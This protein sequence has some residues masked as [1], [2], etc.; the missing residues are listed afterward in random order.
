MGDFGSIFKA[1]DVRGTVPDQFDPD[2]AR[3]IGAAFARFVRTDDPDAS[4]VLVARD[5]RP[6][7]VD[8]VAA[9]SEGVRSQGVDLV[10]LGLGSP[11]LLYYA[12]GSLG[13]AGAVFT[14]SRNPAQY[15]GI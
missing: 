10:D 2:M 12:A 5:M 4:R 6:S 3:A 14:G 15:N 13:A 7:G 1:Y 9:F 8:M 11:D